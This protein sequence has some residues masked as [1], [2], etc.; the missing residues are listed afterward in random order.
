[1]CRGSYTV[2]GGGAGGAKW[3][4]GTGRRRERR[5]EGA[6][7]RNRRGAR[8]SSRDAGRC[9]TWAKGDQSPAEKG[10]PPEDPVDCRFAGSRMLKRAYTTT[11]NE[12]VVRA[13]SSTSHPEATPTS[14][15]RLSSGS[16][17]DPGCCCSWGQ[18]LQA[19]LGRRSSPGGGDPDRL[20][21]GDG[22]PRRRRKKPGNPDGTASAG[23]LMS[24]PSEEPV[25]YREE[26]LR[27]RYPR[28]KSWPSSQAETMGKTPRIARTSSKD[29]AV[30]L[31]S[32]ASFRGVEAGL[33]RRTRRDRQLSTV[34]SV[35]EDSSSSSDGRSDDPRAGS[36]EDGCGGHRGSEDD[37]NFPT[38][39]SICSRT[40]CDESAGS[41]ARRRKAPAKN[42]G[43]SFPFLLSFTRDTDQAT[44]REPPPCRSP[45]RRKPHDGADFHN[46]PH[47]HILHASVLDRTGGVLSVFV[48]GESFYDNPY[49]YFERAGRAMRHGWPD[50][51]APASP[52][53]SHGAQPVP[54]SP[55]AASGVAQPAP[56]SP[57]AAAGVA[58]A[59]AWPSARSAAGPQPV[60]TAV[61]PR[62]PAA[63]VV[64]AVA[65]RW[66]DARA[67]ASPVAAR[68]AP[69]V[70]VAP[71]A[72]AGAAPSAPWPAT[73][74]AGGQQPVVAPAPAPGPAAAGLW[75]A[76][77]SGLTA[78]VQTPAA[79]V[80][81]VRPA[82]A[83]TAA[84]RWTP[85]QPVVAAVV[86]GAPGPAR[87]S[88]ALRLPLSRVTQ[89]PSSARPVAGPPWHAAADGGAL[90]APRP[91]SPAVARPQ[92]PAVLGATAARP[93]TPEPPGA[94]A[95]TTASPLLRQAAPEG[96]WDHAA[97][98]L[99][100]GESTGALSPELTSVRTL[101]PEAVRTLSPQ[102]RPPSS[103]A[104]VDAAPEQ[105]AELAPAAPPPLRQAAPEA[106]RARAAHL[107]RDADCSGALKPALTAVRACSETSPPGLAAAAGGVPG[108]PGALAPAAHAPLREAAPESLR[109]RAAHLIRDAGRTGALRRAL[110]AARGNFAEGRAGALWPPGLQHAPC[111][112]EQRDE[113]CRADAVTVPSPS[114]AAG[115]SCLVIRA[116]GDACAK[117]C[118]RDV[119]VAVPPGPPTATAQFTDRFQSQVWSTEK[120]PLVQGGA[121]G[122]HRG[123]CA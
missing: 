102:T 51:R 91:C 107:I 66:P 8:A 75:T 115:S 33:D 110:T 99:R 101:S 10:S 104:A 84:G 35:V 85:G 88:E 11:T 113:K 17:P 64:T 50:A 47:S 36:G 26:V 18:V 65:P 92:S 98:L 112:P 23:L 111:D 54:V 37:C 82:S 119:A 30:M 105:A 7:S 28:R 79:V 68:G 9:A 39:S 120:F 57:T 72:A 32:L 96:A 106:L 109:A 15:S 49:E 4:S 29:A 90:G 48:T 56:V 76:G 74:S 69:L 71:T 41:C 118:H 3:A 20:L 34:Y 19:M 25:I 60:V 1:M 93:R 27:R 73:C 2:G 12:V 31:E 63:T 94:H 117:L 59:A 5:G 16:H 77:A 14:S 42:A 46:S 86:R 122:E 38:M 87:L 43:C 100:D 24:I 62:R 53:A 40:T 22:F 21:E 114:K 108:Q 67:P 44:A 123:N 6:G 13:T 78:V 97:R 116:M 70:P 58:Q 52:A 81:S 83:Q 55:T 45:A 103:T 95:P 80:R 121:G 89:A 61:A